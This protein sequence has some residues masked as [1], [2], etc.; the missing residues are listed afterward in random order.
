MVYSYRR[1]L[2]T[3]FFLRGALVSLLIIAIT[4]VVI[5]R[6]QIQQITARTQENAL[7]LSEFIGDLVREAALQYHQRHLTEDAFLAK[8][9]DYLE[10]IAEDKEITEAL[11]VNAAQEIIASLE[12]D[13]LGQTETDEEA[14]I[15]LAGTLFV[16]ER[17]QKEYGHHVICTGQPI[18]IDDTVRYVLVLDQSLEGMDREIGAVVWRVSVVLTLG[19]GMLFLLLGVIVNQAGKRIETQQAEQDQLKTIFGNYVSPEVAQ[20]ILKQPGQIQLGGIKQDVTVLFADI[21]GFTAFSEQTSPEHVVRILNQ[22]FSKMTGVIHEFGGTIDKFIGDSVMV[23]FGALIRKPDDTERAVRAALKMQ[24]IFAAYLREAK[25]QDVDLPISLGIGIHC[26]EAIVGNIGSPD[27]MN[28]TVIGD[29]VNFASRLESIA[30][31]G[32]VIVSQAVRNRLT[33]PVQT[34]TL[35]NI[36]IKGKSGDFTLFVITHIEGSVEERV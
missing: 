31:P 27:R 14:T 20:T 11:V 30:K 24:K 23:V 12:T 8:V 5:T 16:E 18:A 28:Y 9:Q 6:I 15:P 10:D 26:G 25:Q 21:R 4:V 32:Q 22:I 7:Y 33:L 3:Q 13:E 34:E 17:T 2:L 35:E 29:T 36:Q 1:Q 19:S